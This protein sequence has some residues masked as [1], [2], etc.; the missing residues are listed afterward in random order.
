MLKIV[1]RD[2][3]V[4]TALMRDLFEGAVRS[5]AAFRD[6]TPLGEVKINGAFSHYADPDTDTLWLGFALGIRCAERIT[7]AKASAS[8]DELRAPSPA[9]GGSTGGE[10]A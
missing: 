7:K 6:N 3:V 4:P 5:T 8:V 1:D 2:G 9:Q 10:G